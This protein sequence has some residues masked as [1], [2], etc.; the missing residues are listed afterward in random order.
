MTSYTRTFSTKSNTPP[1][2]SDQNPPD[3][4][5]RQNLRSL[6][7]SRLQVLPAGVRQES[8]RSH[9]FSNLSLRIPSNMPRDYLIRLAN[10]PQDQL[11]N[12]ERDELEMMK[13]F[14]EKPSGKSANYFLN[15]FATS[16][17]T[18]KISS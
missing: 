16:K 2:T 7:L 8:H 12:E 14:M 18:W 5:R 10:T 11:S 13:T 1:N 3:R 4:Q 15:A 9:Y 17:K 6:H